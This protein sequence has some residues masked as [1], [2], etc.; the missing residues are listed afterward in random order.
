VEKIEKEEQ[1]QILKQKLL[2]EQSLQYNC[3]EYYQETKNK[4]KGK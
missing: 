4:V 2:A 1:I 3:H